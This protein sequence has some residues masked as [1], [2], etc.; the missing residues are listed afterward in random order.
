MSIRRLAGRH[1]AGA[2]D[3]RAGRRTQPKTIQVSLLF[4]E[5]PEDF[6][7]RSAT[8]PD[9]EAY[10]GALRAYV[11]AMGQ[12]GIIRGGNALLPP[13]T[14]VVVR[15]RGKA[16]QVLDGPY[17]ETKEQLG[18]YMAIEVEDM[19]AAIAWAARCPAATHGAVEVR[20]ILPMTT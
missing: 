14:G 11:D 17:A 7:N 3:C 1:G 16:P 19:E 4:H 5:A 13:A 6:A 9:A 10:W 8:G 18:G 20:P 2:T 15:R 12:A